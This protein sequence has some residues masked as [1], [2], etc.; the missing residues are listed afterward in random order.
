MFTEHAIIRMQ[1]RGFNQASVDHVIN[2]GNCIQRRGADVYF[3]SK[4]TLFRMLKC[5]VDRKEAFKCRG[6]YVVILNGLVITVA[7]KLCRFW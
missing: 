4:K 2:F 3:V 5:G 1:Q 6:V 7:Y